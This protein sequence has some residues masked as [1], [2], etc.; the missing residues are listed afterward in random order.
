LNKK[1]YAVLDFPDED[2]NE[3]AERIKE[4]LQKHF[5]QHIEGGSDNQEYSGDKIDKVRFQDAFV[6]NDDVRELA[7]NE[8][9][10]TIIN[11]LYGRKCFPF[12]TLNFRIGTQ[13]HIHSDAVHFNCHPERFMC[14][15]WI[16]LARYHT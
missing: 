10:L 9:I 8:Q 6:V 4:H 1:G 12:Q 15:V 16:A 2:I 11:K 7:I 5:D 3:R 14:G 13:Q